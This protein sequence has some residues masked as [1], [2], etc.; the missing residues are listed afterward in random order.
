MSSLKKDKERFHE[1]ILLARA[2][3]VKAAKRRIRK[4]E[5][6]QIRTRNLQALRRLKGELELFL[7][8]ANQTHNRVNKV[9]TYL[10]KEHGV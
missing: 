3:R 2:K 9:L 8:V 5:E 7:R 10:E 1:K 4:A 6:Q